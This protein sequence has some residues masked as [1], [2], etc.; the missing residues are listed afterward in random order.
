MFKNIYSI[1]EVHDM[2]ILNNYI[3]DMKQQYKFVMEEVEKMK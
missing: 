3:D 2:N 1:F